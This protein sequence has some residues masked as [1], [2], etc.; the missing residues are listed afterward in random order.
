MIHP[1]FTNTTPRVLPLLVASL[2]LAIGNIVQARADLPP[3]SPAAVASGTTIVREYGFE[4]SVIGNQNG[5]GNPPLPPEYQPIFGPT[6]GVA[7]VNYE[8]G[9]SRT[10]VTN[11]QYLQFVRAYAPHF[12]ITNTVEFLGLGIR[13]NGDPRNPN[14]YFIR[15]GRENA[16]AEMGWR[17]AARYCN[18]LTNNQGNTPEAF[19]TG[20][21]DATT[22]TPDPPNIQLTDDTRRL[23]GARFFIPT[24]NEW[25]K[26]MYFD[27]NRF[28]SN[29]PGYW[30]FPITSDTLPVAALPQNGGQTNAGISDPFALMP[31]VSYPN[32]QSPWGLFDG[33]G[34]SRE[35]LQ[36][37]AE[38]ER[39]FRSSS[40]IAGSAWE[41]YIRV[42][43][44]DTTGVAV[45]TG[46]R[47]GMSIP[48]PY[49]SC[50]GVLG[51]WTFLRRKR[52]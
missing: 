25:M 15:P 45:I 13:V 43:R 41:D 29:Q 34:G 7:Q 20:A 2:A 33:S 35:W 40:Q 28:G 5:A 10:E 27:P 9:I 30:A 49:C 17:Y 16:P 12:D 19:L 4:F 50:I 39:Y 14:S 18:W 36:N 21:Y 46:L 47:L 22:F 44:T 24:Q 8:Y 31:I 37:P 32:V 52:V 23:P 38:Y 1:P 26:A 3:L 48:S 51:V 6:A 11:A 42:M